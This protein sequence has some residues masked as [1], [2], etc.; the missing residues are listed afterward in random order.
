MLKIAGIV[1]LVLCCIGTF[2]SWFI[3]PSALVFAPLEKNEK[4]QKAK[5]RGYVIYKIGLLGMIVLS[6]ILNYLAYN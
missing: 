4:E 6:F 3:G 1:T 2:L 5:K